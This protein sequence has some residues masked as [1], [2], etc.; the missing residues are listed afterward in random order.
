MI[1]AGALAAMPG[2]VLAGEATFGIDSFLV[3]D[4]NVFRVNKDAVAGQEGDWSVRVTPRVR[5]EEPRG[6]LTWSFEYAPAYE[7][8]LENNSLRGWDH[9]LQSEVTWQATKRT[10]VTFSNHFRRYG[11][12]S[13]F[14]DTTDVAAGDDPTGSTTQ[15]RERLRRNQ[16][17]LSLFHNL[18]RRNRLT[19]NAGYQTFD[20]SEENASDQ[21]TYSA[22][23]QH[24]YTW[25]P[26]TSIGPSFSWTR[27]VQKP[28]FSNRTETDFLNL[29]LR[30]L[31]RFDP[32]LVL[33]V[34]VGPAMVLSQEQETVAAPLLAGAVPG[35]SLLDI[36]TCPTL[37]DGTPFFSSECESLSLFDNETILSEN[38]LGLPTGEQRLTTTVPFGGVVFNINEA[39]LIQQIRQQTTILTSEDV[40]DTGGSEL[41][42]FADV[43]LRKTWESWELSFG[44]RRSD[45]SSASRF[46]ITSIS[47][48]LY[49][50][51]SWRASRKL[52]LRLTTSWINR[53]QEQETVNFVTGL[54]S[55]S[56]I[57]DT[58]ACLGAG[59]APDCPFVGRSILFDN[60]A[61]ASSLR[62]RLFKSDFESEQFRVRL[63]ARYRLKRRVA[64]AGSV[65]W[66]SDTSKGDLT[67]NRDVERLIA[68]A[69]VEYEFEPF[70]F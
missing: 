1:L 64:L 28:A 53:Q 9:D 60:V 59:T 3:R 7:Y 20:R 39:T 35:S 25:R 22:S 17:N 70:R 42:Y 55:G 69:G 36:R 2:P 50:T 5:V 56:P 6:D 44:Y 66:V 27:Q 40:L 34:S 29:S 61:V 43:S 63:G 48:R 11:L 41:T 15:N 47:D 12:E 51:L 54:T 52:K 37:D 32:T 8:F 67:T 14:N 58:R 19:L 24:F 13:R 45:D 30:V 21:V 68:R 16:V 57:L 46:G 62:A 38:N 33:D 26:S 65:T 23:I 18:T 10:G 31:H 4:N 49:G